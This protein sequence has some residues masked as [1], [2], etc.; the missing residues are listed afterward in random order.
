MPVPIFIIVLLF[1]AAADAESRYVSKPEQV[2][3]VELFTSEG[4]SSCPPAERWLTRFLDH[5]G[6]WQDVIPM[7]F[8]VDYWDYLGWNDQYALPQNAERQRNYASEGGLQQVYTPGIVIAGREYRKFFNPAT[9]NTPVP[10]EGDTPGV[11]MLVLANDVATVT[12]GDKSSLVCH[13]AW[14]GLDEKRA[15]QRG[16]NAGK[17]LVHQFVVLD[18]H[19]LD[20]TNE[21]RFNYLE[22]PENA[23]AVVAW[24][25]RGANPA[26][27]QA[28]GGLLPER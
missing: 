25:S 5:E 10:L 13:L 4:C 20:G 15:I 21:W 9:R 19:E 28:V 18:H 23:D 7:A 22:R 24:V 6:L 3:T 12:F 8:H 17:I 26:P 1:S 27:V 2:T 14:L 16:E 11:L